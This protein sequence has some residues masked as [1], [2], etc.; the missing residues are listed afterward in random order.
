VWCDITAPRITGHIFFSDKINSQ[1]NI[2]Q[3]TAEVSYLSDR[4]TKYMFFLQHGATV[5]IAS[6]STTAIRNILGY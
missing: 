5:H 4:E 6:N 1:I 2:R 3:I